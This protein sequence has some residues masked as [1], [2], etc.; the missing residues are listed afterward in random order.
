MG[1]T[2]KRC[3]KPASRW[4][5][6]GVHLG[7][8]CAPCYRIVHEK[9]VMATEPFRRKIREAFERFV[10][11][12]SVDPEFNPIEYVKTC[13]KCEDRM[14]GHEDESGTLCRWC[15]TCA[16]ASGECNSVDNAQAVT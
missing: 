10:K 16:D 6:Q 11:E 15:V 9:V 5:I 14:T 3:G 8:Y 2:C 7:S 13:E 12:Q 1:E 4:T